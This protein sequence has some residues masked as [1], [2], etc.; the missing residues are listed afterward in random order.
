MK[1]QLLKSMLFVVFMF[2][3]LGCSG[4]PV[5]TD[6]KNPPPQDQVTRGAPGIGLIMNLVNLAT[7][8]LVKSK[9][10]TNININFGMQCI[11]DRFSLELK[12]AGKRIYYKEFS[13][14][15]QNKIQVDVNSGPYQLILKKVT[16][17][18]YVIKTELHVTAENSE[19]S[20]SACK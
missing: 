20:I 13:L 17:P 16:D 11:S 6:S 7:G 19:Y 8:N 5:S 12:S 15:Q 2:F 10:Q 1:T 18:S 14:A 3:K 9:T 4:T